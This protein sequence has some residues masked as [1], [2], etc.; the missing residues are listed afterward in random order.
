MRTMV[1]PQRALTA[2]LIAAAAA[3]LGCSDG[4]SLTAPTHLTRGGSAQAKQTPAS[5][6][7]IDVRGPS[8][9]G[10]ALASGRIPDSLAAPAGK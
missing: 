1:S 7:V 5:S 6:S 8:Y 9:S 3:A 4:G 10:Y 2:A